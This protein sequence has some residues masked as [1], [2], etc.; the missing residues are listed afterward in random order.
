M[1]QKM[2]IRSEGVYYQPAPSFSRGRMLCDRKLAEAQLARNASDGESRLRR[3]KSA[4][5]AGADHAL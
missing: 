2:K 5:M 1:C 4:G 3:L